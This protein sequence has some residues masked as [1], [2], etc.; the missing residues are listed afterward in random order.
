MRI[1]ELFDELNQ[2]ELDELLDLP[3]RGTEAISARDIRRRVDRA[4]DEDPMQRRIHMKR[5]YK[6]VLC[7]ALIAAVLLTGALAT[8]SRLNLLRGWLP[9]D[10]IGELV[11]N[12]EKQSIE[13]GDLRLTLEESLAD[14]TLTYIA[15]SLTALTD[16]GQAIL[17]DLQQ[18]EGGQYHWTGEGITT[19]LEP[20]ADVL[21]GVYATSSTRVTNRAPRNSSIRSESIPTGQPDKLLY[22]SYF[23]G[24]G[25]VYLTLDGADGQL[26][27]PQSANAQSAEIE[28]DFPTNI[29][30]PNG[31][32][33][34]FYSL[35]LTSL[36]YALD[37]KAWFADS[38]KQQFE[39]EYMLHLLMKDGSIR[40][41]TQLAVDNT[42]TGGLGRWN[43]VLDLKTV[44][45]VILNDTAYYLNGR[46]PK[47]YHLPDEYH[48]VRLEPKTI[49]TVPGTKND[50][51]YDAPI[52]GYPARDLLEPLRGTVDWN[53]KTQTAVLTLGEY[54][55][56]VTVGSPT[57][58]YGDGETY[59]DPFFPSLAEV[60]NSKLYLGPFG[61]ERFL[62]LRSCGCDRYAGEIM[63]LTDIQAVY[64]TK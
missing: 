12:T 41:M 15:Y 43:E 48:I 60:I 51:P 54:T 49:Y 37:A 52:P 19:G 32:E 39:L 55:C 30:L 18:E 8:A 27:V 2:S 31:E 26:D 64:Y 28:F 47:P 50:V 22:R 63:D 61:F 17:D 45:A 3:V 25:G 58:Q 33:A 46:D 44:D 13:N 35:H 11:V 5:T 1:S 53:E 40:T 23:L 38:I 56:T 7:A 36:G 9:D 16:E 59:T 20:S 6:K 57:I 29:P 62:G 21:V 34:T 24:K 42:Y 10:G 4:L 14:E